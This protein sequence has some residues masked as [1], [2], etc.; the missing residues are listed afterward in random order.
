MNN[1]VTRAA[2][3][4]VVVVLGIFGVVALSNNGKNDDKKDA[5]KTSQTSD[6]S[7]KK[8]TDSKTTKDTKSADESGYKYVAQAGDSYSLFARKAVQTYAKSA[9]KK[10]SN[11][12]IIYAETTLTLA[13]GSPELNLGETRSFDA[14]DLKKVV[15]GA[16]E[17]SKA[18]LAAWAVYAEG[19]DFDTSK[20]G[21]KS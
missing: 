6:K 18:Q 16:G 14:A 12:Q 17:L 21:I 1:Q 20:V 10:L 11:A 2:V 3:T 7:A 9:D 15:D 13:A 8:A 19:V 5:S 4:V